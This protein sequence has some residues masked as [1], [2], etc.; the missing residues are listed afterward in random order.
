MTDLEQW[1]KNTTQL[2][3]TLKKERDESQK[4][5]IKYEYMICEVRISR[6]DCQTLQADK[7][8]LEIS[9]K[10]TDKSAQVTL[11]KLQKL[12]L[13]HQMLKTNKDDLQISYENLSAEKER[14]QRKVVELETEKD[15][16]EEREKQYQMQVAALEEQNT[17]LAASLKDA[18][19]KRQISS[20]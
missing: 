11:A 1:R 18:M 9:A 2:K 20:L 19:D 6:T 16:T 14:L 13:E 8:A 17:S 10:S 5:K 15:T 4:I 7:N 3:E 12:Q